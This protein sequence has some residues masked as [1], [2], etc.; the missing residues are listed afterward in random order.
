MNDG[1]T[2]LEQHYGLVINHRIF[3]F[4]WIIPLNFGAELALQCMCYDI[5]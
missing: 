4:G 2:G 5:T 3:I 1:L